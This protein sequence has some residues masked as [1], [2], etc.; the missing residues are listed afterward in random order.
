MLFYTE[1][2]PLTSAGNVSPDEGIMRIIITGVR[3]DCNSYPGLPT[4]RVGV[5]LSC[6]GNQRQHRMDSCKPKFP[7]FSGPIPS[8][9]DLYMF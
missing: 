9:V 3:L 8:V 5:P 1:Q 2:G 6:P 7:Y 4:G